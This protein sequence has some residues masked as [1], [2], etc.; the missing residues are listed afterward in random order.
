MCVIEY[1]DLFTV[2][3]CSGYW[4]LF[5]TFL[6]PKMLIPIIQDCGLQKLS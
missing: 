6:M 1:V 3:V 5:G 2:C 4:M